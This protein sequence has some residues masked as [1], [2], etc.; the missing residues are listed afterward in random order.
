M[1]VAT[2]H[3]EQVWHWCR[4]AYLR[5]GINLSFPKN[6]DPTKTY[7]WRYLSALATRLEEWE[8]DDRLSVRFV[9]TVVGYAKRRGLLRKGLSIFQQSNL[10]RVCYEQLRIA[11][12]N[13]QANIET[14]A[15]TRR[16]LESQR[17][18]LS[19]VSL[20]LQRDTIGAYPNIVKWF[21]A[22]MLTPLYLALSRSCGT[23]LLKLERQNET[24]RAL[25]PPASTLLLLRTEFLNC[26]E[27][28]LEIRDVLKDDWRLPCRQ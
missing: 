24:E 26:P 17:K 22:G 23:A 20:L 19:L 16:W 6:T 1:T 13:E 15:R 10:L 18:S 4:R 11:D 9:D 8:F 14:V 28:K 5:H 3:I 2:E 12:A 27:R 21:Q 7:Q 25:L